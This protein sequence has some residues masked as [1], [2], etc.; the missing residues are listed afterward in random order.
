MDASDVYWLDGTFTK[1]ATLLKKSLVDETVTRLAH[2]LRGGALALD[3]TNLYFTSPPYVLKVPLGGGM[4]TT[5]ASHI[6]SLDG[7]SVTVDGTNMYF[8]TGRFVGK[9]PIAGGMVTTLGKTSSY[10]AVAVDATSVYWTA[11]SATGAVY[12]RTPK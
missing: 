1:H 4:A 5:L 3:A 12:K 2:G 10:G 9:V 6:G 8:T 7:A 11:A